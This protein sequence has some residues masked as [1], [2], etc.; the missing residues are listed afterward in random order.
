MIDRQSIAF[1]TAIRKDP[2]TLARLGQSGSE[3]ELVENIMD[4]AEKRGFS[5]TAALVKSGLENLHAI[6]NETTQGAELSEMELELVSG[7]ISFSSF[8][9]YDDAVK[10]AGKTKC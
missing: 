7:G 1:Y 2:E 8:I 10:K 3:A 5:L 4:E 6:I 9:L